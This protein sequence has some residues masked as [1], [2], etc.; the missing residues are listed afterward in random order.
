MIRRHP[1]IRLIVGAGLVATLSLTG[2][3]LTVPTDPQ[4]TLH[5]VETSGHLRAGATPIG[6]ALVVDD[7]H[8]SGPLVDLIE[9]FADEHG[10]RVEWTVGSEETL[11]DALES[12]ELDLAVGAMTDA[13]PWSD[14]V[15]VTRGYPGLAGSG[16]ARL[17]ALLPLGENALQSA[18]E[19]YLDEESER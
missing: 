16:D 3:A 18:L 9:G 7:D 1:V 10:A 13:T 12:G 6:D 19:T 17:V 8:V 4:G 11:V 2:C 5:H 15:S 14:R